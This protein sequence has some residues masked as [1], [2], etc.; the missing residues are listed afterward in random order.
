MRRAILSALAFASIAASAHA[1][2]TLTAETYQLD[3]S[4]ETKIELFEVGA[5]YP[6]RQSIGQGTVLSPR[7]YAIVGS[8]QR[9]HLYFIRVTKQDPNTGALIEAKQTG[10][11]WIPN[12]GD[13]WVRLRWNEPYLGMSRGW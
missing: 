2:F 10:A 4:V 3:P 5:P 1:E 11:F 13:S 12:D 6:S 7:W 8:D 9:E